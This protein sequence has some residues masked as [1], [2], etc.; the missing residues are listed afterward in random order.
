MEGDTFVILV[1]L[2]D[3][4]EEED[5]DDGFTGFGT[6]TFATFDSLEDKGIEEADADADVEVVIG[7]IGVVISLLTLPPFDVLSCFS[8]FPISSFSIF[9]RFFRNSSGIASAKEKTVFAVDKSLTSFKLDFDFDFDLDVDE[10][11]VEAVA[12]DDDDD[13]NLELLSCSKVF[14]RKSNTTLSVICQCLV[15]F[16][17]RE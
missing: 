5:E 17:R 14:I 6:G 16:Y 3:E 11:D 8:R 12:V 1:D 7:N 13:F 10:D 4:V 15:L 2:E 9:S